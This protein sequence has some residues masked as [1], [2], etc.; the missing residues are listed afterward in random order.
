SSKN[1]KLWTWYLAVVTFVFF[2]FFAAGFVNL[3]YN[4]EP[5]DAGAMNF[6][7]DF[8]TSWKMMWQTY[9]MLLMIGGLLAAVLLF[10]WMYHRSHWQVI[11][12]TEGKGIT[13]R[14]KYFVGATVILAIFAWGNLS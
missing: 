13:Y 11:S 4:L 8:G 7:E 1:K 12:K 9:P 6:A 14:R 10:R 5:L 3:S 2:F